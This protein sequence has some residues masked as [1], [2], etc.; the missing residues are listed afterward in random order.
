MY[1]FLLNLSIFKSFIISNNKLKMA[2]T[3]LITLG[4]VKATVVNIDINTLISVFLIDFKFSIL[5]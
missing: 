4:L 3:Q 5:S 2:D 1:F